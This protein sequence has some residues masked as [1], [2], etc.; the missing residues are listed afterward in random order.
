[1]HKMVTALAATLLM[2]SGLFAPLSAQEAIEVHVLELEA[3]VLDANGKAVDGLTRADLE[4]LLDGKPAEVTNFYAVRRGQVVDEQRER[5]FADTAGTRYEPASAKSRLIVVFDEMHLAPA[6]RA[7]AVAA[8]RK[9]L[10]T[11]LTPGMTATILRYDGMI[12]VAA[13][14]TAERAELL[15]G[16]AQLEKT[17]ATEALRNRTERERLMRTI[18]EIATGGGRQDLNRAMRAEMALR[19]VELYAVRQAAV[20]ERTL[21]AVSDLLAMAAGLEGRKVVLYVSEGIPMQPGIELFEYASDLFLRTGIG[22]TGLGLDKLQGGR[23]TETRREHSRDFDALVQRAQRSG[24]SFSALDPGG[25]RGL[26]GTGPEVRESLGRVNTMLMRENETAGLRLV[27][28]QTGGRF[29]TNENNLDQAIAVLTGD[30]STYYSLGV[31]P[32]ENRNKAIDV[33]IR[34]RGRDDVRVLTSR[35]RA[36]TSRSE[37]VSSGVRARL[38]S[39]EQDNVLKARAFLGSAWPDG[40]RCVAPVQVVVPAESLTFLDGKAQVEVYA[41]ALDE[42]QNESPVRSIQRTV[43]VKAG[44][45]VNEAITFGFQ[46]R[47][48][49]VSL[50]IVDAI[51][52]E[53]SYLLTDVDAKVCGY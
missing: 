6:G 31:H 2:A 9:Y 1:M 27:A 43:T 4:V 30:V 26:E 51:S 45:S 17:P 38:Y 32:P 44:E 48:Y 18:D 8:L 15:R 16:L 25:I 21:A 24:I 3:V 10:D 53:T 42:Q 7:R 29:I 35:N 20:S 12:S 46:P 37:A 52:G 11:A 13:K 49:L 50:A 28:A 47:R 23:G 41:I 19:D 14:T 33:K 34:V 40:K 39:R 5:G 36:I 22:G